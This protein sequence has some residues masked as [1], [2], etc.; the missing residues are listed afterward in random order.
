M[1]EESLFDFFFEHGL[2]D[3]LLSAWPYVLESVLILI[4]RKQ[5]ILCHMC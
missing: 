2:T 3:D 5:Q 4:T 1:M